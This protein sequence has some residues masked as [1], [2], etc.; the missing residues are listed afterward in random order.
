[1]DRAVQFAL[2]KEVI[3]RIFDGADAQSAGYFRL[4]LIG[5]QKTVRRLEAALR[6]FAT[7]LHGDAKNLGFKPN[8]NA[9]SVHFHNPSRALP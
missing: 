8:P 9:T 1:V 2:A 7:C 4:I 3:Q 6:C 5:Q